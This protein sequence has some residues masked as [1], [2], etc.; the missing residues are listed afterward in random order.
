MEDT[1]A[2][3]DNQQRSE[4]SDPTKWPKLQWPDIFLYLVEKPGVYTHEKL[5]AYKSLDVYNFVL[6]GH[7]QDIEYRDLSDGF[8]ALRTEVLPSQRQGHKTVTLT[9]VQD[10][11]DSEQDDQLYTDSELHLYGWVSV[12]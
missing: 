2:S 6:C 10:L 9:N 7:V 8:C 12:V 11:G 1:H 4:V 5:K 3:P